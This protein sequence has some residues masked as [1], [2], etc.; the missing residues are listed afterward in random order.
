METDDVRS[1]FVCILGMSQ[2]PQFGKYLGSEVTAEDKIL[3]FIFK[4]Y[5]MPLLSD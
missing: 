3:V 4:G 5:F 2:S 1:A